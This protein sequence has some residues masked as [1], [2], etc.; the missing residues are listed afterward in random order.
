MSLVI[1]NTIELR[2]LD[3]NKRWAKKKL[4]PSIMS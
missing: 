1:F 3:P 4:K 2:A